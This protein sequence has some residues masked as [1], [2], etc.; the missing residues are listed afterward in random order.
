MDSVSVTSSTGLYYLPLLH[1]LCPQTINCDL[2]SCILK[3]HIWHWWSH[4]LRQL[5][6]LGQEIINQSETKRIPGQQA[7]GNLSERLQAGAMKN[8]NL[9]LQRQQKME[10]WGTWWE[11]PFL[12]NPSPPWRGATPPAEVG[13]TE[14]ATK[15][16]TELPSCTPGTATWLG[17]LWRIA[18]RAL[19]LRFAATTSPRSP[20]N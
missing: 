7:V 10:D 20:I 4:F 17:G 2:S 11:L 14:T 8:R 13:A 15:T 3:A 9:N 5:P 19:A 12:R 16:T 18:S 1:F 6:W